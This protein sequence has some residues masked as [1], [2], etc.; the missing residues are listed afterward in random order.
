MA[1]VA[2]KGMA[3]FGDREKFLAW[4]RQPNIAL[5]DRIPEDLL[6]YKLGM[7]MVM[8]ELGRIEYGVYS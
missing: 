2:A 8:D 6:S 3:V 7:D 4:M 1:E 5:A